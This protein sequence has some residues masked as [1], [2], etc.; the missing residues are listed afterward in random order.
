MLFHLSA[1][2]H[3]TKSFLILILHSIYYLIPVQ[4]SS[5]LWSLLLAPSKGDHFFNCVPKVSYTFLCYSCVYMLLQLVQFSSV[6]PSCLTH[7]NLMD[8]STTGFPIH[9]QLLELA[10]IHV[11][12]VSDAIQPSH[13]LLLLS[14]FS[15]CPQSFP[16]SR[17]FPMSQFF[18]SG[19]QSV[20]VSASASVLPM[21]IQD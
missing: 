2:V 17:S 1:Y 8:C 18:A 13:P 7:C 15:S 21:N 3:T 11:H 20:G 9:H 10:Q 19:G 4:L 16:E 14:L 12:R 6:T 5:S